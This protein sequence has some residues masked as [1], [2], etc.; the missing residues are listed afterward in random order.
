MGERL[1]EGQRY[2]LWKFPSYNNVNR[3]LIQK[4][5]DTYV[6]IPFHWLR[7]ANYTLVPKNCNYN[8]YIPKS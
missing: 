6:S 8:L 5:I 7:I 3:F 4:A 2:A 1:G